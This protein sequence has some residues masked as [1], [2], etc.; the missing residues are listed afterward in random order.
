[1]RGGQPKK[2]LRTV[3]GPLLHIVTKAY[4]FHVFLSLANVYIQ[5]SLK[6]SNT[7]LGKAQ[8]AHRVQCTRREP[9][10]MDSNTE[11]SSPSR[12]PAPE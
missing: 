4:Q 1:M 9:R 6:H 11:P 7:R 10:L 3:D 2:M 5:K 12:P 8:L